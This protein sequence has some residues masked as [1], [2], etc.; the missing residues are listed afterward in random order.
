MGGVPERQPLDFQQFAD[1]SAWQ[2]VG[3]GVLRRTPVDGAPQVV[4]EI[5]DLGDRYL[6][7]VEWVG[8]Y[9]EHDQPFRTLE[10]AKAH[11]WGCYQQA[12]QLSAR[13]AGEHPGAERER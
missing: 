8:R 11:A 7:R 13:L 2:Y 9:L 12:L 3:A 5:L 1:A 10:E 6:P 4:F